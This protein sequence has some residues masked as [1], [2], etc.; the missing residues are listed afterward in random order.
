[1]TSA[2]HQVALDLVP[3]AKRSK[4][5]APGEGEKALLEGAFRQT[6]VPVPPGSST[7]GNH[8]YYYS[9]MKSEFPLRSLEDFYKDC[10]T[11]RLPVEIGSFSLDNKGKQ[12]MDKSQLKFFTPPPPPM[13]T[14]RLNF[15]LRLGYDKYVP[16]PRGVPSDKLNPIL[17]WV[18]INGD[19]F[20]PKPFSPKSPNKTEAGKEGGSFLDEA[21]QKRR[22][23]V[24]E[25]FTSPNDGLT[26]SK[27]VP[28][29][30]V[31]NKE[32]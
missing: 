23:S 1:M 31:P 13:A 20:R 14:S 3:A 30:A 16:S 2:A 21:G 15:D 25:A 9:S 32:R 18:S 19:S 26:T 17:R 5:S 7:E 4:L 8:S 10:P 27:S 11:Y 22:I 28:E 6:S 29:P 24:G 12:Q